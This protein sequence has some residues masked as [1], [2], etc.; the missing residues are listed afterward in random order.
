VFIFNP[1]V[2]FLYRKWKQPRTATNSFC[3]GNLRSSD[4]DYWS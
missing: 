2:I 1:T 3:S 4:W